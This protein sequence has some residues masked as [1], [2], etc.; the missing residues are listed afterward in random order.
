[1]RRML[2]SVGALLAVLVADLPKANSA[3][4]PWCSR[5]GSGPLICLYA[6]FQQCLN[7]IRGVGGYCLQN[8]NYVALAP[9]RRSQ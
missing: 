3:P 2:I 9:R 7:T 4:R 5:E 1:M 8:P 6:T